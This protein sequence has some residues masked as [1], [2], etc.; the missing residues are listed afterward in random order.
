M[1]MIRLFDAL[2]GIHAVI[3]DVEVAE[4]PR[5]GE[6]ILHHFPDNSELLY[7]VT[8]VIHRIEAGKGQRPGW[9][10]ILVGIRP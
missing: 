1:V 9:L 8:S 7:N 2:D 5:V 4:I 6:Q 3:D 10:H